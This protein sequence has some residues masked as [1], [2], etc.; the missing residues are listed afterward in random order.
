MQVGG[1][2]ICGG[3]HESGCCI[4]LDDA[5]K[6][7]NYTGNQ[8]RQGFHVGSFSGYQQGANFNQ[9]QGQ[10][11]RSHLG[12][13]FNK[14]QGGPSNIP[15]NQGPSLFERTTK[16][17]ETLAHFMQ[18]SMSNHKSTESAIKNLEIQVG[19]LAK[20][21]ADNSFRGFGANTEKI[22]KE[23]CKPVMTRSKRATIVENE[24]KIGD[25]KKLVAEGEKENEEDQ[26]REKKI[27]NEEE[28][29]K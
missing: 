24:S 8:N 15:Q 7:V 29:K 19:Q 20:Q 17:E 26:M 28:E 3:A 5:T 16:M 12:N 4:P 23:E 6:E 25:D 22:L 11:W 13:Q 9:N 2:S 14:D 27:N 10:G 1:Y 21:I 18:V